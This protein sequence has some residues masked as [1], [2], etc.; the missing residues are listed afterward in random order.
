MVISPREAPGPHRTAEFA[1]TPA[2]AGEA[3]RAVSARLRSWRL[4]QLADPV[5]DGVGALLADIRRHAGPE[6]SCT[7]EVTLL[8]DRLAVSARPAGTRAPHV[9]ALATVRDSG[10]TRTYTD[11]GGRTVWFTLPVPY[12]PTP[13]EAHAV[14]HPWAAHA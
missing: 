14:R 2:G 13:P 9:P 12:P 10:G 8:W 3:G 5:A 1:A 6:Q 4:P 7:V 11:E